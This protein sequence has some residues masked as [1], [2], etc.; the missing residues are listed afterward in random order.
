MARTL[1]VAML[2]G[3]CYGHCPGAAARSGSAALRRGQRKGK[4]NCL[5]KLLSLVLTET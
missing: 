4:L 5:S 2:S 1:D 3:P